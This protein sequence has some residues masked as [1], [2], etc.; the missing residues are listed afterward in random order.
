MVMRERMSLRS[1]TDLVT[2]YFW[3]KKIL[4]AASDNVVNL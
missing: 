2:K 1:Q 3:Q 4:L